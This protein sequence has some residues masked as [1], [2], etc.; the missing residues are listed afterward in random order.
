MTEFE[1]EGWYWCNDGEAIYFKGSSDKYYYT[2]GVREESVGYGGVTK[3]DIKKHIGDE[4]CAFGY[5]PKEY[6]T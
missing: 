6:L 1:F 4:C 2:Y 3:D 5:L